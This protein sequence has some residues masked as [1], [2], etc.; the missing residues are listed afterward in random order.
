MLSTMAGGTPMSRIST[1]DTD[2]PHSAVLRSA[3]P[4]GGRAIPEELIAVGL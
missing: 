3:F 4:V 2:T 1:E